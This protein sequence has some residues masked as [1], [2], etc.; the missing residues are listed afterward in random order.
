MRTIDEGDNDVAKRHPYIFGNNFIH[1][2]FFKCVERI[3]NN[4]FDMNSNMSFALLECITT[5]GFGY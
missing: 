2:A 5:L 4:D 3:K 1:V